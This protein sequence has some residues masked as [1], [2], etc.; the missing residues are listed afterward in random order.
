MIKPVGITNSLT[1]TAKK[2]SGTITNKT[3]NAATRERIQALIKDFEECAKGQPYNEVLENHIKA[4]K[5]ALKK[6]N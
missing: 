4:L 3:N 5:E 2:I 1:N 6:Y